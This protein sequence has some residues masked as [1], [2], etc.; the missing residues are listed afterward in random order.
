MN[1]APKNKLKITLTDLTH[2]GTGLNS[3]HFPLGIGMLAAYALQE[4]NEKIEISLHK[5]PEDLLD[6]FKGGL[7]DLFCCSTY[8]WN[9]ELTYTIA[10]YVKSIN[11]RVVTV[12]GGPNFP[13]PRDERQAFLKNRPAIDFFVKWDGEHVFVDLLKK[14]MNADLNIDTFKKARPVLDNLCYLVDDDYIEGPDTRVQDL[15]TIPSPYL[16]GLMDKFF[17]L[18]LMPSIETTRG[19]PFSCTFCNDGSALRSKIFYRTEKFIRDELEYIASHLKSTTHPMLGSCD[20]NFGMFKHDIATA[21]IL[22]DIYK[23]YRWPTRFYVSTG[24]T[25]TNRIHQVANLVNE[26]NLDIFK[27]GGS[28]QSTNKKVL[29]KIK[30]VNVPLEDFKQTQGQKG[31]AQ[32]FTELIVPLPEET[33]ES[34]YNG[35]KE[36]VDT[37]QFNNIAIHHL[38]LLKGSEL[39]TPKERKNTGFI[40]RY[41]AFVGCIGEYRLGN[42]T[43]PIAEVEE[44]VVSTKT[45]PYDEYIGIRVT[46]LL[47]KTF[48]DGDSFMEIFGLARH[49]HLSCVDVLLEIQNNTITTSPPLMAFVQKYIQT[50]EAK[51]FGTAEG[52]QNRIRMPGGIDKFINSELGQN[53]LSTFRAWAYRDYGHECAS[54]LKT[55]IALLLKKKGLMTEELSRFLAEVVEF[56]NLRRF[57]FKDL[58]AREGT[59]NFDFMRAQDLE[60]QVDPET[61]RNKVKIRFFYEDDDIELINYYF[62]FYENKDLFQI[63]RFIQQINWIKMKRKI[64]LIPIDKQ[65]I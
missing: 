40:T 43:V 31:N 57:D 23:R 14:L 34:F 60:F 33:K 22:N 46:T 54:V 12:F 53:E 45:M 63:G 49:M 48:I 7:P 55:T 2:T 32:I 64:C 20:L 13:L 38:I 5:I 47:I 50:I 16:A 6:E 58:K 29:K 56:C 19:C 30:R 17:D 8:T 10:A 26:G 51:L 21:K 3:N 28:L 24:K 25:R 4:L 1:T 52:L 11:P 27:V 62:D 18:P 37:L 42:E 39:A 61:I 65:T 59:F 9:A 41:R 15:M 36:V 44:T 35:L